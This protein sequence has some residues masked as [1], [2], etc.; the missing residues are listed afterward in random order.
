METKLSSSRGKNT[1]ASDVSK[2]RTKQNLAPSAPPSWSNLASSDNLPD[3]QGHAISK[4]MEQ[5]MAWRAKREANNQSEEPSTTSRSK[6]ESKQQRHA[7]LDRQPPSFKQFLGP[8][9]EPEEQEGKYT[10]RLCLEVKPVEE[11]KPQVEHLR[12][13]Q[14]GPVEDKA[15]HYSYDSDNALETPKTPPNRRK[16]A[17]KLDFSSIDTDDD[18]EKEVQPVAPPQRRSV[19]QAQTTASLKHQRPPV[20][21]TTKKATE[22]APQK[23]PETPKPRSIQS[24]QYSPVDSTAPTRPSV[25]QAHTISSLNHQREM[26]ERAARRAAEKAQAQR[27]P[28]SAK[29]SPKQKDA[30][31]NLGRATQ[32]SQPL[33]TTLVSKTKNVTGVQRSNSAPSAKAVVAE[34]KGP[35]GTKEIGS[36]PRLKAPD[37]KR[38]DQTP[39][40]SPAKNFSWW[41]FSAPEKPFE[42]VDSNNIDDGNLQ[43][44]GKA[45][46]LEYDSE[47][48]PNLYVDTNV[49]TGKHG[50]FVE[51][52]DLG[53]NP[54]E[55]HSKPKRPQEE[56]WLENE[57]RDADDPYED[58]DDDEMIAKVK[59][60]AY[61][62]F[63]L[64]NNILRH[65]EEAVLDKRVPEMKNDGLEV[66]K[67]TPTKMDQDDIESSPE[68]ASLNLQ[69]VPAIA[70]SV[71]TEP[72]DAQPNA[73]MENNENGEEP[74]DEFAVEF[75]V[76]PEDP[77]NVDDGDSGSNNP[78]TIDDEMTKELDLPDDKKAENPELS[79]DSEHDAMDFEAF[80]A[81]QPDEMLESGLTAHQDLT[82]EVH[83]PSI[84]LTSAPT[85]TVETTPEVS[86]VE[87]AQ[88]TPP[89]HPLKKQV[90]FLLESPKPRNSIYDLDDVALST[91]DEF[92][93]I[94][95]PDTTPLYGGPPL[96]S[97]PPLSPL[98]HSAEVEIDTPSKRPFI[99][100]EPRKEVPFALD[101]DLITPPV[102]RQPQRLRTGES[103]RVD[104]VSSVG[105]T[106]T[107]HPDVTLQPNSDASPEVGRQSVSD[108]VTTTP[109]LR[110]RPIRRSFAATPPKFFDE[111]SA[112][113]NDFFRRTT[114]ETPNV[115]E[116]QPQSE[117]KAPAVPWR[118]FS[119]NIK[120]AQRNQDAIPAAGIP[121]SDP[122]FTTPRTEDKQNDQSL[123]EVH[124]AGQF[125]S[126][127]LDKAPLQQN[128]HA[129]QS[130]I[131]TDPDQ[132][133]LSF[134]FNKRAQEPF[135]SSAAAR[136][137]FKHL[138]RS[139][140]EYLPDSETVK[141]IQPKIERDTLSNQVISSPAKEIGHTILPNHEATPARFESPPKIHQTTVQIRLRARNS[142]SNQLTASTSQ[143]IDHTAFPQ[144]ESIPVRFKSLP[145]IH[146]TSVPTRL[147]VERNDLF[148]E[149]NLP[150][151]PPAPLTTSF[152]EE[153]L[154]SREE[155]SSWSGLLWKLV[156]CSVCVAIAVASVHFQQNLES[157]VDSNMS[158]LVSEVHSLSSSAV[159]YDGKL[160]SWGESMASELHANTQRLRDES[161]DMQKHLLIMV[162]QT[163]ERNSNAM[164]EVE[165]ALASALSQFQTSTIASLKKTLAQQGIKQAATTLPE[166]LH[167]LKLRVAHE[168]KALSLAKKK[169]SQVEGEIQ[170]DDS[171]LC[172]D[173]EICLLGAELSDEVVEDDTTWME[174]IAAKISASE[175][176]PTASS[177]G[178]LVLQALLAIEAIVIVAVW[179]A[180]GWKF[181][182]P[183]NMEANDIVFIPQSGALSHIDDDEEEETKDE[184]IDENHEDEDDDVLVEL[185]AKTPEV[186]R[187]L[188]F[189]PTP[190]SSRRSPRFVG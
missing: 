122:V 105:V 168:R 54:F 59:K 9:V 141:P 179:V 147:P 31:T 63:P 140:H 23:G 114:P 157:A 13:F 186:T 101:M 79:S 36:L 40:E 38:E 50:N 132:G 45:R 149:P 24:R 120:P 184:E 124:Q 75:E 3:E 33:S 144:R 68:E 108:A 155:S 189:R 150:T 64:D 165:A 43:D 103:N 51:D 97:S 160:T 106:S 72:S 56:S 16:V 176:I 53:S 145:K 167:D 123:S 2:P 116:S 182:Q 21:R 125:Q 18:D 34:A 25:Y 46:Q 12:N 93:N 190:R 153:D 156:T 1:Q 58:S 49:N 131:A 6:L 26:V 137:V 60:A 104:D 55:W 7:L 177:V 87:P 52:V 152:E 78:A 70:E 14:F 30:T 69:T 154:S 102:A 66:A 109:E 129:L 143:D 159:D 92:Q 115:E 17:V 88:Q 42:E 37:S 161:A 85:E 117:T 28:R 133:N 169:H 171:Q 188:K 71:I 146:S 67:L 19:L 11:P 174:E 100:P 172:H 91:P 130:H 180:L 185:V 135:Q 162:D 47:R 113:R 107:I 139:Q 76:D 118:P 8:Q 15:K 95:L 74:Q 128:A 119:R 89:I 57:V 99:T 178:D 84:I 22:K 112:P 138:Q 41:H 80:E 77:I 73:D 96:P 83:T 81:E 94:S 10:R 136:P 126:C 183:E 4:R 20:E 158:Q 111:N 48:R 142:Q 32:P 121:S 163:K 65:N 39:K 61:G 173:D 181:K 82:D 164:A 175:D 44:T 86:F 62:Y 90:T 187:H 151:S 5:L 170:T 127:H 166:M 27:T 134:P 148:V 98:T 110:Q 29:A 35:R